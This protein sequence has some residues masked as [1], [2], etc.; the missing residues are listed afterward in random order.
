MIT[1]RE[2]QKRVI[3][4]LYDWFRKN[5]TGNPIIDASVGSGKSV[6]LAQICLDAAL[7]FETASRVLMITPTKEL[8]EQNL[9]KLQ[10]IAPELRIGVCSASLGRKETYKDTDVIIGTIGTLYRAG[11]DLWAFA[12]VIVDECHLVSRKQQGMYRDLIATLQS[13]SPNLRVVGAT[14]TPFRGTGVWL[15]D[16]SERLFTDIAS[17]LHM[18]E[19]LD[20]GYL[21]PLVNAPTS[22]HISGEGVKTSGG[23]YVVS[24]LARRI[25][26]PDTTKKIA[27]EICRLGRNRRKWLVYCVTVAHAEHMRNELRNHGVLCLVVT[28]E[29]PKAERERIIK[30]FRD[31]IIKC[32]VNV[33]CLT[34]GFDAPELDFIALVRNT[35]SPV[36]YV[37]IA[38]RGMRVCDGKT[39]CLF[40]DFTDTVQTLGPVDAIKGK[41]EQQRKDKSGQQQHKICTEC[42]ANNACGATVCIQCGYEFP[43][44]ASIV[45]LKASTAPILSGVH[46]PQI[47]TFEV[48]RVLAIPKRSKNGRDY[49]QI[50]YYS[51]LDRFTRAIMLGSDGWLGQ[52]AAKEWHDITG[53]SVIPSTVP[54]AYGLI[55]DGRVTLKPVKSI[56]VDYATKYNDVLVVEYK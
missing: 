26:Q 45:H 2:N 1:L 6:M 4:E 37:Q 11:E 40:A 10:T 50:I 39:D 44:P 41:P 53:D 29:T 43:K 36:L 22:T 21:A 16:G 18:R 8:C 13:I 48:E 56:T 27:E 47:A 20:E 28:G 30:E 42:A 32:I 5:K 17:R 55:S 49:L 31:G 7:G 3:A 23:D 38:G 25:D 51:G 12:L 46:V 54:H 19:L 24:D 9:D 15:H 33:C 35:K 14:G 52:K 34:T